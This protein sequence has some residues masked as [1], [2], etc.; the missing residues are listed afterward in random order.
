MFYTGFIAILKSISKQYFINYLSYIFLT[1]SLHDLSYLMSEDSLQN[2]AFAIKLPT[3]RG[4]DLS[5]CL[6]LKF[7]P[8]Y[9]SWK[10]K[11]NPPP[12]APGMILH[13]LFAVDKY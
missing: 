8:C 4:P 5:D 12:P 10:H 11:H 9:S 1:V 3:P 13:Y 7:Q 2:K 6:V